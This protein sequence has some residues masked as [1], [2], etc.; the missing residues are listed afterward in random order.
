MDKDSILIYSGEKGFG[1]VFWI[2][3]PVCWNSMKVTRWEDGREEEECLPCR[4]RER[5]ILRP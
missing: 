3:C 4:T 2:I 5:E 1:E